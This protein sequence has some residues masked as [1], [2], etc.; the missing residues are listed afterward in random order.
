M[1]SLS[2][3]NDSVTLLGRDSLP[4][5]SLNLQTQVYLTRKQ[6]LQQSSAAWMGT[7]FQ[8]SSLMYLHVA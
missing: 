3:F 6:S 5:P 1:D 4:T 7:C 8:L 2:I